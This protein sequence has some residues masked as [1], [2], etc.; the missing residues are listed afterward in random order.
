MMKA[1]PPDKV[2]FGTMHG[3]TDYERNHL[4]SV[5]GKRLSHEHLHLALQ[6]TARC[7][8]KLHNIYRMKGGSNISV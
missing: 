1:R 8:A 7:G 6:K 5:I 3:D 2:M 4:P